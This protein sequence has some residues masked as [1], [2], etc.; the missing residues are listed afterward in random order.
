MG[1]VA[2]TPPTTPPPFSVSASATATSATSSTPQ[3][4][5]TSGSPSQTSSDGE[6]GTSKGINKAAIGGGVGGALAGC[7]IVA[8]CFLLYRAN[9]GQQPRAQSE[10]QFMSEHT[11][12]YKTILSPRLPGSNSHSGAS[13]GSTSPAPHNRDWEAAATYTNRADSV[14]L[15]YQDARNFSPEVTRS[16]TYT[17]GSMGSTLPDE[18]GVGYPYAPGLGPQRGG[19]INL[20]HSLLLL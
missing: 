4:V 8:L 16:T 2:A 5:S 14:R 3:P 6:T 17:V 13:E 9:R 7:I 20:H 15:R 18:S 11:E 19:K 1:A 12:P 10:N